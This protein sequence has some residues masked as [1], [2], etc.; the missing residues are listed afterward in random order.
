MTQTTITVKRRQKNLTPLHPYIHSALET[1]SINNEKL[2]NK[3]YN[4]HPPHLVHWI[5]M[6]L[7]MQFIKRENKTTRLHYR[8]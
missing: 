5:R 3:N 7:E 2:T 1:S 8:N 6:R 4:S